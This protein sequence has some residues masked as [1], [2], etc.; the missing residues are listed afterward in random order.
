MDFDAARGVVRRRL[1]DLYAGEREH[2]VVLPYGF[3]AGGSWAPMVDW[4]GV[5]GVYVY[6]VDKQTGGLTPV[7]FPEFVDLPD[8]VRAGKWPNAGPTAAAGVAVRR[9]Q[10]RMADDV[11][12]SRVMVG[13]AQALLEAVPQARTYKRDADGRFG[14]GGGVRESLAAASTTAEVG[15]AASAEARRITGRDIPFDYQDIEPQLAREYSEGVL[16]GLER[17]PT[18]PL[19]AVRATDFPADGEGEFTWAHAKRPENGTVSGQYE[20]EFN[21]QGEAS[22]RANEILDMKQARGVYVYGDVRGLALHEF[23]H[24]MHE[25]FGTASAASESAWKWAKQKATADQPAPAP[26]PRKPWW[27]RDKGDS[28]EASPGPSGD[29]Q[30]VVLMRELSFYAATNRHEL[31]AEA[32]ADVMVNGDGASEV[33][34]Q[35]MG[36]LEAKVHSGG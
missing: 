16:Q 2:P 25:G 13:R 15:A 14:S 4:R 8:P 30:K 24:V 34:H 3:D 12:A 33:S 19:G 32:F 36:Q 9:W 20:I 17:F 22:E 26:A 7:S 29:D 23:G 1:D 6:L 18:A 27:R 31:S 21:R 28:T 11:R 35:I 5:A 10:G